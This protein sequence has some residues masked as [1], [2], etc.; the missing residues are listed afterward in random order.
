M[1]KN[2]GVSSKFYM[3]VLCVE[4]EIELNSGSKMEKSTVGIIIVGFDL[5]IVAL[6]MIGFV[7]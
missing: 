1:N 7:M 2:M 6:F 3:Q 4:T 5:A